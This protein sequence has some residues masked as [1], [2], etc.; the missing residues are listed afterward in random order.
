MR[1]EQS[2]FVQA[3]LAAWIVLVTLLHYGVLANTL[4]GPAVGPAAGR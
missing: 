2:W 1:I 3:L 4:L